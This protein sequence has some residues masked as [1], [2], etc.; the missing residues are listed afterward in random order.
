MYVE[1]KTCGSLSNG[2][3]TDFTLNTDFK[4]LTL[5][6]AWFYSAHAEKTK[7]EAVGI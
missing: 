2:V 1:F 6:G 4:M 7:P 5:D 3:T